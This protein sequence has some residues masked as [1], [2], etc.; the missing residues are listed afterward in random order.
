MWFKSEKK[1]TY[2]QECIAGLDEQGELLRRVVEY[3]TYVL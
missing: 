3:K 1:G 2:S